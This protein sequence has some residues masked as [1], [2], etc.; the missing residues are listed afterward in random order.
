MKLSEDRKTWTV[1]GTNKDTGEDSTLHIA[2]AR[3]GATDYDYA[4]LVNECGSS[5]K[6]GLSPLCGL[7][8]CC[9]R[10]P[11]LPPLLRLPFSTAP[12]N[13]NVDEHCEVHPRRRQAEP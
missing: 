4:M 13:I 1:S 12:R 9:D 5:C 2:Y 10:R 11:P 6:R 7:R 3:A 8:A